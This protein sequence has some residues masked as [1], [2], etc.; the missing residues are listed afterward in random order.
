MAVLD[1]NLEWLG[2]VQP[3]GLVLSPAILDRYGLLP[4][5]QTRADGEAVAAC[6]A[7]ESEARAFTD[8]WSFFSRI[9]GWR[10]H[11]VAGLPGG[12]RL[13]EGLSV[14]I[15]EADAILEPH[16][17]V[18]DP[19]TL[20]SRRISAAR[21]RAGRRR[22]TSASSGSCARTKQVSS[23]LLLTDDRASPCLRA[24]AAKRAAGCRFRCARWR[25]SAGRPML[26]GLQAA[27]S[28][29]FGFTTMPSN[30]AYLHS[31]RQ[32]RD[33][34][35]EVST[36]LAAQVL[37]A[38]HELLRGLYAADEARIDRLAA[39]QPDHLYDGLAHSRCC[40]S[41]SSSTPRIATSSRRATDAED[42]RLL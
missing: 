34:Q 30:D 3:V 29:R 15:D 31:S 41:S 2:Y 37:G 28:R 22:R 6:L 4:E 42:A 39:Q 12:Q 33:A 40:G 26:G 24:D 17:A 7:S 18:I 20:L 25:R 11:H 32:S 23:R 9:L 1:S 21:S 35:A 13:P 5:E 27:R 19:S 8:P 38:L 10:E 14:A 36:K 16:W